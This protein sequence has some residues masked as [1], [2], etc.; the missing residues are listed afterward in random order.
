[1]DC[2][3]S[4]TNTLPENSIWSYGTAPVARLRKLTEEAAAVQDLVVT[5]LSHSSRTDD[6][7]AATKVAVARLRGA[8][9]ASK[10]HWGPE[11][12]SQI[13]AAFIALNI[14]TF[15]TSD[16]KCYRFD[17]KPSV[18][19]QENASRSAA[20]ID[21]LTAQALTD[22]EIVQSETVGKLIDS[23][24]I[25]SAALDGMKSIAERTSS[26]GVTWHC[27]CWTDEDFTKVRRNVTVK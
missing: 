17:L 20:T 1:M 15:G 13:D 23:F 5:T 8:I 10:P 4:T 7:I 26:N 16:K 14:G 21:Q 27:E 2:T 25:L 11:E 22:P 18:A 24:V 12:S 6:E 19:F 3:P 9:A